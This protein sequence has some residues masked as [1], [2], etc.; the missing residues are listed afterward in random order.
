MAI[1]AGDDQSRLVVGSI[2]ED[3]TRPRAAVTLD[4]VCAG[5]NAVPSKK[6]R[7]I[8]RASPGRV[9]SFRGRDLDDMGQGR[10]L[11]QGQGR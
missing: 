9:Q 6:I 7:D 4:H 11:K 2:F 10:S 5:L 3:L 1:A 8:G